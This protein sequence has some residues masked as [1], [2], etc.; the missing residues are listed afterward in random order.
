[1]NKMDE[2]PYLE[3]PKKT[4]TTTEQLI[5]GGGD[6]LQEIQERNKKDKTQLI[7]EG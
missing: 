5:Y 4:K 2:K 7:N 6:T 3:V 1:M